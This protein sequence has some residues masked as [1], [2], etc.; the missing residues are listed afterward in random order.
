MTEKKPD[1]KEQSTRV[2]L[3]TAM[4]MGASGDRKVKSELSKIEREIKERFPSEFRKWK[5]DKAGYIGMRD[6]FPA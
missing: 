4:F 2:L 3:F 5:K 1:Y 6:Y